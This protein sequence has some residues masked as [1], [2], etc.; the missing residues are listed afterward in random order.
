MKAFLYLLLSNTLVCSAF[1]QNNCNF[2][3]DKGTSYKPNTIFQLSHN[4]QFAIYGEEEIVDE[5]TI[6]TDFCLYSCNNIA[7]Y[8]REWDATE[9]CVASQ[10][11]DTVI[12][13]KLYP[14]PIGEKLS[15]VWMEFFVSKFFF[16]DESILV[17]SSYRTDIRKYTPEEIT[18]VLNNY[19]SSKDNLADFELY[20]LHI[21]QL[22]WAYVS[23][24]EQAEKILD[25]LKANYG[26]Y[27]GANAADFDAL[28]MTYDDLKSN[29]NSK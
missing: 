24:S 9:Y 5:K 15:N 28:I 19:S 22:I 7:Y 26:Q 23:G 8:V 20:L 25:G 18:T 17:S 1:C 12:I 13:Q 3:S 14:I 16:M 29:R 2:K 6:Y 21:N 27:D 4:K 11:G 10:D